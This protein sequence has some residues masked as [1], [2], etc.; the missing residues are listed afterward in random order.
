[1]SLIV[2]HSFQAYRKSLEE[3]QGNYDQ[4]VY[5]RDKL[6]QD[7]EEIVVLRE[8]EMSVQDHDCDE[9]ATS[10]T[11]TNV[12]TPTT[13]SINMQLEFDKM[14]IDYDI[15][16]RE[17]K[18]Y[19]DNI[20]KLEEEKDQLTNRCA[21]ALQGFQK[22]LSDRQKTNQDL[23]AMKQDYDMMKGSNTMNVDLYQ[24]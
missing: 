17:N 14:K 15:L 6:K 10:L 5:H 22:A 19:Q 1:M 4:V 8:K 21:S 7:Y 12:T 3:L 2:F 9:K 18:L 16:V 24:F 20:V 11:A 23:L 13:A